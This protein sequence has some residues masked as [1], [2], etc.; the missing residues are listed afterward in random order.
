ML[1]SIYYIF[2]MGI[3]FSAPLDSTESFVGLLEL[4]Q[5]QSAQWYPKLHEY[6]FRLF[7][8]LATIQFV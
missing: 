5:K 6:G 4:I 2:F 1:V 8:L 3:A 7:W